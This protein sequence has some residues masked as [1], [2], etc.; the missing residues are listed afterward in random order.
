[1]A[2]TGIA[3]EVVGVD[4][5]VSSRGVA[6]SRHLVGGEGRVTNA[7][8][9]MVEFSM[10]PRTCCT[11]KGAMSQIHGSGQP[12]SAIGTGLVGWK[13]LKSANDI[14]Q[15]FHDHLAATAT[16]RRRRRGLPR[17]PWLG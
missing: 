6:E 2:M 7:F 16:L 5:L 12:R 8:D 9:F 1:M 17:L 13:S 15:L 11:D 14:V 3:R 4:G 10:Y